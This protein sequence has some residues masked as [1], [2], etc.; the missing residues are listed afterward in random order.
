MLDDKHNALF[1]FSFDN[2]P[3]FFSAWFAIECLLDDIKDPTHANGAKQILKR[4]KWICDSQEQRGEL[5]VDKE[6]D[7]PKVD[8]SMGSGDQV[9]LLV[10]NK[11]ESSQ[12]ACLGREIWNQKL[13]SSG[14]PDSATEALSN[15][16][17]SW[18]VSFDSTNCNHDNVGIWEKFCSMG[19]SIMNFLGPVNFLQGS[20]NHSNWKELEEFVTNIKWRIE[21]K[22][23]DNSGKQQLVVVFERS[24]DWFAKE[25][26]GEDTSSKDH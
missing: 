18:T 21:N 12:D 7:N 25:E 26:V 15:L 13:H 11:D 22:I 1:C 9:S 24:K 14:S 5:K 19:N 16:H 10:N 6:D 8:E 20:T 23:P 4:N 3:I 17:K 2:L